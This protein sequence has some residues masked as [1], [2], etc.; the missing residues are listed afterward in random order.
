MI[1]WQPVH[2]Q[3][4][5]AISLTGLL[6]TAGS[7]LASFNAG[8][9]AWNV[10]GGLFGPI[11]EFGKNKRR[12]EVEKLKTEQEV[13]K[14]KKT[15]INAFQEV[16][17]ALIYLNTY[18]D[19]LKARKKQVDAAL[20][21]RYLAELRY[22]KGVTSYLEVIEYQRSAFDAEL[23]YAQTKRLYIESFIQL[24]KVLGGGWVSPEE[25]V[26]QNEE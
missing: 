12:V 3:R 2:R 11:F 10:G 20:N 8:G 25:E 17:N 15:V 6:G 7:S 24:Y 18:K 21:A 4:F 26:K 23:T 14:Y 22:D 5:P 16:E 1:S 13:L 9:I 19:Q